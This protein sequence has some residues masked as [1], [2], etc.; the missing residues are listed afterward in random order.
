MPTH[1]ELDEREQPIGSISALPLPGDSPIPRHDSPESPCGPDNSQHVELYDGTLGVTNEFVRR[2]APTTCRIVWNTD[3]S[4]YNNA[5]NVA[6]AAFCTG[7]LIAPNLVL[8]AAHCFEEGGGWRFP[9]NDDGTAL[10]TSEVAT[11]MHVE[12][13]YQLDP[14]GDQRDSTDIP[15]DKLLE[16]RPAGL[17]VALF[18]VAGSPGGH[19]GWREVAERAPR[20]GE[21]ITIIQHPGGDPKKIESGTVAT[22]RTDTFQYNDLDTRGGS[23]GA[24]VL[25]HLGRIVGVHIQGGCENRIDPFNDA[26]RIDRIL[27][28]SPA[29]REACDRRRRNAVTAGN[30]VT[31]VWTDD[32]DGDLFEDISIA[33]VGTNGRLTGLRSG[34]ARPT[35]GHQFGPGVA[36]DQSGNLIM[37][38]EDDADENDFSNVRLSGHGTDYGL[39]I[40]A[41]LAHS[42]GA[43]QQNAPAVASSANG[44]FVVVWQ[45]DS[46][47][48]GFFNITARGFDASGSERFRARQINQVGAGQQLHPRIS[49][50]EDGSFVII[51]EDDADSNGYYEIRGRVFDKDG[52]PLTDDINI[53]K[54]ARGQQLSPAVAMSPSGE[55]FGAAW[56]DDSDEN[57]FMNVRFRIFDQTGREVLAERQAHPNG[58]GQQRRPAIAVG[59]DGSAAIAWEDDADRN[60]FSNVLIRSVNRHGA[61]VFSTRMPHE[62]GTGHQRNPS[63]ALFSSGAIALSLDDDRNLDGIYRP[64]ICGLTRSG[65][66]LFTPFTI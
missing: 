20:Y 59:D 62:S 3:L 13:G 1:F 40:S 41:R 19:F 34:I 17:D 64:T 54:L 42:N 61:E 12:F 44:P 50:A 27:Q 29:I 32:A 15:I 47:A 23:S 51:W 53:N 43:G 7:T 45:D 5:H 58:R 56:E 55:Y 65:G 35:R 36:S 10:P 63:L 60:G 33:T 16:Y 57:S 14:Q 31:V 24:G 21:R 66:D 4:G 49:A 9:R 11:N 46:D 39:Q 22:T 8:T 18:K 52:N 26:V 37:V 25:D 28:E 6:G 2:Y 30:D 48:N 38:W